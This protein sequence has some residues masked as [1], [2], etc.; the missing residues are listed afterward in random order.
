MPIALAVGRR[1]VFIFSCALLFI[2]CIVASQV[3]NYEYH[4]AIRIVIGF[5]AGQS[6][7]LVPLMLKEVFFLHERANV[8]AF[9]A[10]FQTIVGCVLTIFAS[11][12]AASVGWKNW[13]SVSIESPHMRL[14]LFPNP[15]QVYAG[16]SGFLLIAAYFLVPETA[17]ERPLS[18]YTGHQGAV[19]TIPTDLATLESQLPVATT[20]SNRPALDEGK[21]GRRTLRKDVRLFSKKRDWMEAYLLLKHCLEMVSGDKRRFLDTD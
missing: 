20:Q 12:I 21:Y 2:G 5:A 1:P 4:L 9:Q 13:Y 7:A 16:L 8:L 18:A 10:S 15:S 3:T 14:C 11:N 17:Y 6:E 19:P